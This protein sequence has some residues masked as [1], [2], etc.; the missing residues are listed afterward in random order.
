MNVRL[1]NLSLNEHHLHRVEN[2]QNAQVTEEV[3]GQEISVDPVT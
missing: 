2:E 1:F 3:Q